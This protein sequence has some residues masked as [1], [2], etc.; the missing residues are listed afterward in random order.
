[1]PRPRSLRFGLKE[2]KRQ[3]LKSDFSFIKDDPNYESGRSKLSALFSDRNDV[4]FQRADRLLLSE[5]AAAK[6]W[7]D[8]QQSGQT[9]YWVER[10]RLSE[11]RVDD[12][13]KAIKALQIL[14]NCEKRQPYWLRQ[15]FA[16]GLCHDLEKDSGFE[17]D[18]PDPNHVDGGISINLSADERAALE[19]QFL[20]QAAL[21]RLDTIL[22]RT[23]EDLQQFSHRKDCPWLF[24]GNL[25]VEPA[26]SRKQRAALAQDGNV[27][28][29]IARLGL[30]ASLST[31][32]R[33]ITS[34]QAQWRRYA[35][36]VVPTFGRPCWEIVAD[37]VNA[38][39]PSKSTVT[40]ESVR[41]RWR[42]L[43]KDRKIRLH[44]WPQ[45]GQRE[46]QIGS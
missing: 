27:E 4:Q 44:L 12:C 18:F 35:G 16:A 11:E 21:L 2:Q 29:G 33:H 9:D 7:L 20:M 15:A 1:M 40:A 36:D 39:I 34:G 46:P 19:P 42:N 22:Q 37:Y 14:A 28:V 23:I 26:L 38:A 32:L 31:W 45:P 24:V 17:A 3:L 41:Q 10:E 30:S 6:N 43:S 5:C 13:Q 8:Q 25:L